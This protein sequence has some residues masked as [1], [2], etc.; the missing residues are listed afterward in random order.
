VH[1]TFTRPSQACMT[2]YT[3]EALNET[4][5]LA[6]YRVSPPRTFKLVDTSFLCL[7]ACL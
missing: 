1:Q 5:L 4:N 7:E 6:D 2:L 3:Q